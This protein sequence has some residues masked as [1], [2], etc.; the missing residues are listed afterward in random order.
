[1]GRKPGSS[2]LPTEIPQENRHSY[3]EF[4]KDFIELS[5]PEVPNPFFNRY[6]TE[7]LIAFLRSVPL[8]EGMKESLASLDAARAEYVALLDEGKDTQEAQEKLTT[9]SNEQ[10]SG[11]D[12]VHQWAHIAYH[13]INS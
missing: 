6:C 1:M 7:L 5:V 3:A 4:K 10:R 11:I 12:A 8:S 13:G 9:I 2:S